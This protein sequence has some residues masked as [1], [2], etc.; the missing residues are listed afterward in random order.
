MTAHLLVLLLSTAPVGLWHAALVPTSE[1]PVYFDVRVAAGKGGK[2]SGAIVNAG[3]ESPLSSVTW[4]GTTLVL[5][6]ASY[7]MTITAVRSG[8]ALDGSYRRTVISG[9]AEVPF[10]ASRTAPP[11]PSAPS[12]GKTLA[13]SWAVEVGGA[14]GKVERL[15]GVFAQKGAVL[16]GTLLSITGDY[17]ALHGWFDGE[18]MLLTVFDGVHVY[19]YDGELLPDGTLAGEYRSRTAPPVSWRAS[20]LDAKAAASNLP[21]GF[22]IVRAKDPKER[23][24]FSY[25]DAEGKVVSSS[26]ARF[27]GK[28]MV[29]SF[30]GTWCP[31]CADEAPVLRDLAA[32]Y[33][34]KGVGFV[35]LAFEYTDDVER[36]RRQVR[37]FKERFGVTYPVLI[38]GTT[39]TAK[40]TAA[41]KP[42]EGFEG[43]PTTLFL[44]K[45]HRIVKIHSGF[46]GPA[47]GDRYANAKREFEEAVAALLDRREERREPTSAR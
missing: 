8:D 1:Y 27:A 37:R 6:I 16:T 28:P 26:D 29:V 10:T 40:E 39:R 45:A 47:T 22:E 19:R 30:M 43:Y 23:Y 17:G 13:G 25:P 41:V 35:S 20:R 2:L 4:D 32:R 9:V 7:D 5:A 42:L 44:D 46:D 12:N 14:P 11:L 38:A 3:V 33:G 24:A 18:R 36:N 15:T 34:P 31:N 21:G